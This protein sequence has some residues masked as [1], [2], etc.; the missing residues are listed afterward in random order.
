MS[1]SVKEI[2]E[3]RDNIMNVTM[4]SVYT[5][6][7]RDVFNKLGRIEKKTVLRPDLICSIRTEGLLPEIV[8]KILQYKGIKSEVDKTRIIYENQ[9]ALDF[10][11]AIYD[12]VDA[13]DRR[14][15][16][17]YKTYL[18]VAYGGQ[19]PCCR[20]VKTDER[21]VVPSKSRTSDVGYDLTAISKVKDISKVTVMLDTG[22]VIAPEMGY[23]AKIYPRSSLV[24]S[25]YMLTNSVGII[26]GT[27]RD[28]LK[29]CLTKIDPEAAEIELPFK[30]A[31]LIFEK[32][33]Y[34]Y[35]EESDELG[36]TA[37][38]DG[39]FGSTGK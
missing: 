24:K 37:R 31:Q 17:L 10:L 21:A 15:E 6:F 16:M 12:G 33:N 26:D 18:E 9:N 30:C 20:F 14:S 2:N 19:I 23:Y 35:F 28:S 5:E 32:Q 22:I 7:V 36:K 1:K 3:W 13:R 29:I 38:G 4:G 11:S 25:G 39:G 8:W 27:F 34:V